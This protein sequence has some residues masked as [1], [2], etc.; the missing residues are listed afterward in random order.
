MPARP[1][2]P[3]EVSR[4]GLLALMGSAALLRGT[5]VLA[6]GVQ[7]AQ[8]AG[9]AAEGGEP[10]DF[11]GLTEAMRALATR[12]H[13]APAKAEG[14]SYSDIAVL[15]RSHFHSIEA[16]IAFAKGRI[17]HA[18][19]SGIGF[20]EQAHAKD[21]I[22][23][24]RLCEFPAESLAF[25]RVLGLLNGMGP[26]TVERSS[27]DV[28]VIATGEDASGIGGLVGVLAGGSG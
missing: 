13:E 6:E 16:Q 3:A 8:P 20:F 2:L 26:A 22:A 27:A 1:D 14:F 17:P 25:A 19:T 5:T 18:I 9:P 7:P 10:F 24:L 15:Y 4:R 12:P 28:D 11:D 23:L 21:V